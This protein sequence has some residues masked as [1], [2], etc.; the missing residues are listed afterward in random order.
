MCQY[1]AV[2]NESNH[3]GTKFPEPDNLKHLMQRNVWQEQKLV[4]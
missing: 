3:N 4:N 2:E 1:L